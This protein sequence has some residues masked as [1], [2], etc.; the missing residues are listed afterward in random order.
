LLVIPQDAQDIV[1]AVSHLIHDKRWRLI[2]LSVE[3]GK[4][5]EVF[6]SIVMGDLQH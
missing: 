6:R 2:S 5:D 3:R 1:H 4:L